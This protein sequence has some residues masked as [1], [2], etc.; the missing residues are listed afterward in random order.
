MKGVLICLGVNFGLVLREV[1]SIRQDFGAGFGGKEGD[2][3]VRLVQWYYVEG[4]NGWV[5]VL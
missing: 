4:L 3:E 2:C 1:G 5:G